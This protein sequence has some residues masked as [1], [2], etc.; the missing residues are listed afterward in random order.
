MSYEFLIFDLDGTLVD[1]QYDLTTAVNLMRKDFGLAPFPVEKVSSYLGSG[2]NALIAKVLPEKP[3]NVN[4]ALRL[5][6]EHYKKHLLD[7]TKLYDGVKETLEKLK[8]KK[9]ALLSNKTEIFCREILTRLDIAKYFCE[10][11]G[12][13]SAGVKKPD[14]KPILDLIKLSNAD[15]RKTVMIGDSA[16][17]FKAAKSA[18]VDSIA[19]SYGYLNLEGIKT[20]SPTYI[21]NKFDEIIKITEKQGGKSVYSKNT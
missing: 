21:V 16:N 9:I 11:F 7:T 2:V 1:S 10:I 6:T 5:F 15:A 8:D 3:D 20:F 4:E 17:D 12:G 13:D 19:V 18:N 14:P